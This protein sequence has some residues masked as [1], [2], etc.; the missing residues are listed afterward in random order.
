MGSTR[1]CWAI[2]TASRRC[3]R[4]S[5]VHGAVLSGE[6]GPR[7]SCS[8]NYRRLLVRG[9][10][11][12]RGRECWRRCS[13]VNGDDRVHS[14]ERCFAD[15]R[16]SCHG[17]GGRRRSVQRLERLVRAARSPSATHFEDFSQ[18]GSSVLTGRA[19]LRRVSRRLL[20]VSQRAGLVSRRHWP[21]EGRRHVRMST[22]QITPCVRLAVVGLLIASVGARDRPTRASAID[23]TAERLHSLSRQTRAAA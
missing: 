17:H 12:D 3:F 6:P 11:A 21:R 2:Y 4:V 13:H 14:W 5:Y 18:R 16:S 7:V 22:H 23:V 20:P 19:L 9:S 10:G 1:R 15:S 8:V